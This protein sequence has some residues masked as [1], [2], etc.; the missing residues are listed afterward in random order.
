MTSL[1]ADLDLLTTSTL[2][3][4]LQLNELQHSL[5]KCSNTSLGPDGIPNILFFFTRRKSFIRLLVFL[6]DS[7]GFLPIKIST[8]AFLVLVTVSPG[9][10][11]PVD[12]LEPL[13]Q[14]CYPLV[15]RV[16]PGLM[17]RIRLSPHPS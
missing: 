9:R 12:F 10:Y 7:V 2:N 5:K 8:M 14:G 17:L 13:P 15:G 6:R 1:T 4:L 16:Y 3:M 11:S